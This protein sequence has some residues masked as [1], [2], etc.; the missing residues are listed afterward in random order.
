MVKNHRVLTGIDAERVKIKSAARRIIQHILSEPIAPI[1]NTRR[2]WLSPPPL[3]AFK[4]LEPLG[5]GVSDDDGWFFHPD[6]CTP[7]VV[8]PMS[9]GMVSDCAGEDGRVSL[10]TIK[11]VRTKDVRG[12]ASRFSPYMVRVDNMQQFK[13][14]MVSCAG[15]M[16]WLGG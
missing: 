12:Y 11:T 4:H 16:V 5:W 9:V 10:Q 3:S 6:D 1:K 13:E 8:W 2:D 14:G 15:L 7:D